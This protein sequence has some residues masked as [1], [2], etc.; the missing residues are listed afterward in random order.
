M[1]NTLRKMLWAAIVTVGWS[2]IGYGNTY[3]QSKVVVL[4][5]VW[6]F[7]SVFVATFQVQILIHQVE[8]FKWWRATFG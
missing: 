6:L 1:H 3:A 2:I 5:S 4:F 8:P 7:A